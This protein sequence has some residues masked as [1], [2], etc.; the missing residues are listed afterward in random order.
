MTPI[1]QELAS[2]HRRIAP[3]IESMHAQADAYVAIATSGRAFVER[4]LTSGGRQEDIIAMLGPA[5]TLT[6]ALEELGAK[7][8]AVAAEL[9][10]VI[11]RTS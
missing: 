3:V 7:L 2:Q 4:V 1:E 10:A 6:E 8:T 11:G 5:E 9:R